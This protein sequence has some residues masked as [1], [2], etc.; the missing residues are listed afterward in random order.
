MRCKVKVVRLYAARLSALSCAALQS[1][2][3]L[4]CTARGCSIVRYN[5]SI[6]GVHDERYTHVYT[7]AVRSNARCARLQA[8]A[9]RTARLG[10]ARTPLPREPVHAAAAAQPDGEPDHVA[11]DEAVHG[12]DGCQRP[13]VPEQRRPTRC[14]DTV[15]VSYMSA[16]RDPVPPLSQKEVPY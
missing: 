14:T 1:S 5:V 6:G 16:P 12:Y 2:R 15:H 3:K 4:Q 8:K 7:V 11:H 9:L 10:V 13:C